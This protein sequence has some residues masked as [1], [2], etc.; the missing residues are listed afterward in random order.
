VARDRQHSGPLDGYHRKLLTGY[1]I[2]SALVSAAVMHGQ[3]PSWGAVA[4]SVFAP[5][6]LIATT[7]SMRRTTRAT[8][9]HRAGSPLPESKMR[10]LILCET[11]GLLALPG[12]VSS[13]TAYA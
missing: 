8:I 11:T 4:A 7:R 3:G 13:G 10:D 1:G 6:I 5:L 12:F 9:A 2:V